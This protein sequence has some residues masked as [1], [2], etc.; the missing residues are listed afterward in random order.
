MAPSIPPEVPNTGPGTE[1]G[2]TRERVAQFLHALVFGPAQWADDDDRDRNKYREDAA[3]ALIL[4]PHL[5]GLDERER[6]EEHT[7]ALALGFISGD[8]QIMPTP[9]AMGQIPETGPATEY[10]EV[11]AVLAEFLHSI[12]N[13]AGTWADA[14]A[15]YRTNYTADAADLIALQPHLIDLTERQ[16]L[17][18]LIPALAP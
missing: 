17:A 11:L 18:A 8:P 16:R 4:L 2:D 13:G 7:P 1:Y 12:P 5:L 10:G 15:S 14:E 9:A 6:L 3:A